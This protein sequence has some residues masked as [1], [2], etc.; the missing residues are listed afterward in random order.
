MN[1]PATKRGRGSVDSPE[2]NDSC[3][4]CKKSARDDAIQCEMCGDWEHK[5]CAKVS[6]ELYVVLDKVPDNVKF[7]CTPCS[8]VVPR[9]LKFYNDMNDCTKVVNEKISFLENKLSQGLTNISKQFSEQL[10]IIESKLADAPVVMDQ[11]TSQSQ[12]KPVTVDTASKIVDEYRD[13]EMRKSNIIIFNIPE[14]KSVD[15]A[16]WKKEDIAVINAIAEELGSTALDFVGVVRLGAKSSDKNRPL[17]VQLNSLSQRRF[18]LMKA[19]E[20][21]KSKQFSNMYINPDLSYKERQALKEL[22]QELVRRKTAGE[23]DIFIR[24][25]QIVKRISTTQDSG[26]SDSNS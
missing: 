3:V 11:E 1:R 21:R 18:L 14:P 7:F 10:K 13:R 9:V 4:S 8:S 20:L 6:D 5:Q 22:R 26:S 23:K 16:Q 17:K 19:K 25:G 24:R 2:K 12:S 15:S